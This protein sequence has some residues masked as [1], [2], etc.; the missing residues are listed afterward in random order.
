MYGP[1][2]F[3]IDTIYIGWISNIIIG[4]PWFH[5]QLKKVGKEDYQKVKNKSIFLILILVA[6]L[7]LVAS[8]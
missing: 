8:L 1:L 6:I 4:I 2:K 3:I 5:H 7:Y